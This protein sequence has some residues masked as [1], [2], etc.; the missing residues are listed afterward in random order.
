MPARRW[1]AGA[2]ARARFKPDSAL[3]LVP[4]DLTMIPLLVTFILLGLAVGSFLNV[5]IDR[6]PT[7]ESI[8]RGASHCSSCQHLLAPVDLVPVFSYLWLR[9]HCRYCGASIPI[10]VPLVEIA[11]GF[12]FGFLYWKF[13]LG[14]ELGI[15]LVY[16]CILLAI[17]LSRRMRCHLPS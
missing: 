9:G 2:T 12:L 17:P 16:A 14:V 7:G 3:A 11:T 1:W 4:V 13:G 10:R 5:C 15:A 6:L 8:V